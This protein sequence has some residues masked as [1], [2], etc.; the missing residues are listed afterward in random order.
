MVG[1]A[2]PLTGFA[3]WRFLRETRQQQEARLAAS[4]TDARDLQ[5]FKNRIGQ[6]ATATDL[7]QDRQVLRVALTA[8]GL[9]D[10][11]RS[12]A[13]V[14]RVLSDGTVGR[15]ALSNRLADRRYRALSEAFGFGPYEMPGRLRSDFVD[16][17]ASAYVARRFE[18]EVGRVD[19]SLRLALNAERELSG[20]AD[21]T[22]SSAKTL[23]YEV[24]ATPPVRKVIE[25]ALG[26]P[27]SVA[28][29]D[30][31]RQIGFFREASR[32]TFGTDHLQELAHPDRLEPI[33]RQYLARAGPEAGTARTSRAA[34][35]L[36][37]LSGG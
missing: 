34:I 35:A 13:L 24:L 7:V 23:W 3:G 31:D 37:L 30:L 6:M 17:I 8:F 5:A 28:A 19:E 11:M 10:D 21:R 14:E 33:L 25:A 9:E 22:G 26:L 32:A 27:V 36:R 1:V 29:L 20:F 15:D 12:R 16:R 2:I 18:A 4:P